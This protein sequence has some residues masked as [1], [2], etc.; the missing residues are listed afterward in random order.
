MLAERCLPLATAIAMHLYPLCAL[1][2]VPV[3]LLSIARIQRALLLNTIRNR[4][5][6]LANAGS[7][8]ARGTESPLIAARDASGLTIEGT[9]EYMSLSS[10]ADVV[11]FKAHFADSL[12]T[13]LCAADLRAHPYAS[14]N[15]SSTEPCGSRTPPR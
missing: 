15:G 8:R 9:C 1:Q 14:A 11:L 5:L 6:I 7:E 3:P 4:S 2:C 10:V 13:A 12:E